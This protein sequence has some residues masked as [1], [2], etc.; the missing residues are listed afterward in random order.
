MSR[1]VA[2][3]NSIHAPIDIVSFAGFCNSRAE[4][5]AHVVR[6]EARAAA[7][8]AKVTQRRRRAA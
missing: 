1:L 8:A 7:D 4:L 3:Q 2:A 5:E 6:Y